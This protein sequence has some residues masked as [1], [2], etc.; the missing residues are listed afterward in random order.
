[1]N[2]RDSS[3]SVKNR[4][5]D[6]APHSPDAGAETVAEPDSAVATLFNTFSKAAYGLYSLV[7]GMRLT[8][9]YLVHPSRVITQ[10]YPENRK[11]L[12]MMPRFRGSV[13]MPHDEEGE[14][15]C[16][17]CL[18]C[19]KACPNGSISV[20]QTTNIA[21]KKVLGSYIYRM[22]QCAMC[23]L[24]VEACPFDAII[25]GDLFELADFYPD[26]FILVLNKKE[27]RR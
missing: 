24:C 18:L 20:L 10:Q 25:M 12:K 6:R 8:F 13:I 16:S 4:L 3:E 7:Q 9:G 14:H 17:A 2:N 23:N 5:R 15:K 19:E 11:T 22:G 21:G 1:M 26:K 27:G